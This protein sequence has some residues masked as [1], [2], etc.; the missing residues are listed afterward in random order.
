M[1]KILSVYL[2]VIRKRINKDRSQGMITGYWDE[3]PELYLFEELEWIYKKTKRDDFLNKL[4]QI[5]P[6]INSDKKV[7]K[8]KMAKFRFNKDLE[9]CLGGKRI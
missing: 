9:D 4:K 1:R 5:N 8:E 3:D 2:N 6:A 7:L